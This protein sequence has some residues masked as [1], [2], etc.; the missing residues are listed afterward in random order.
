[1]GGCRTSGGEGGEG[2]WERLVA[3]LPSLNGVEEQGG[4]GRWGV[5]GR[6]FREKGW[7]CAYQTYLK[8]VCLYV[9]EIG[10]GNVDKLPNGVGEVQGFVNCLGAGEAT[11]AWMEKVTGRDLKAIM[12]LDVWRDGGE[13][14]MDMVGR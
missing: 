9:E 2:S 10:A 13:S 7:G 6:L 14:L 1:M 12:R 8:A 5:L 11:D 4:W 3:V